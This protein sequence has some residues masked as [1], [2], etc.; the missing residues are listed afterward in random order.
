MALIRSSRLIISTTKAWR[1]GISNAFTMPS[2]AES[3]KISPHLHDVEQREPGERERQQHGG[4]LRG[5]HDAMA[6]VAVG[7]QAANRGEQKHG[8]LAGKID[9]T[10]QR[11]R[12]GQPVDQPGQG[13]GLHPGADQRNNLAEEK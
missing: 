4:D 8:N 6:A 3:T 1:A 11:R 7:H 9:R 12:P 5:D 2:S 13:H 10:E